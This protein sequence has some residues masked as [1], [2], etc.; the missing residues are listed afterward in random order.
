MT[1]EICAN[2]G[3]EEYHHG[4]MGCMHTKPNFEGDEPIEECSCKKFKPQNHSPRG[5]ADRNQSGT[6]EARQSSLCEKEDTEPAGNHIIG[7]NNAGSDE[8]K[9]NVTNNDK[10]YSSD[11]ASSLS[12]KIFLEKEWIGD[13][14]GIAT[15]DVKES[16][17]KLIKNKKIAKLLK[18]TEERRE[19]AENLSFES[20]ECSEVIGMSK[21]KYLFLSEIDK[22]FGSALI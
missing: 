10:G 9:G 11:D 19:N 20:A 5:I 22:I 2:C 15:K 7:S 14:G 3:H 17:Q 13:G 4:V 18:Q 16:V 21:M 12:D 8:L 6:V 1:S